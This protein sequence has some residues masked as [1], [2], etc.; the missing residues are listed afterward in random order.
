MGLKSLLQKGKNHIRKALVAGLASSALILSCG[1]DS[2]TSP[3]PPDPPSQNRAPVIN[4]APLTHIDEHSFYEY[5]VQA[6]DPD[7]DP[8]SYSLAESPSWL[9]VS[10]NSV[11]GNPPEVLRDSTIPV[12]VKVSDG[13]ASAEQSYNLN[14]QNLYNT[15][16]LS[17]EQISGLRVNDTSLSFFQPVNFA[18]NDLVSSGIS[19][20]TPSGLLREITSISSDRKTVR[21]TQATLEQVVRDASLSYSQELSPSTIQSFNAREGVSMSPAM[22]PSFNFNIGLT[23]V[24]LYD[25]DG[26]MNTTYDQIIA[27]GNL[28]FNTGF[29]FDLDLRGFKL[30]RLIFQNTTSDVA[31]ITIGSNLFGF[32]SLQEVKIAEYTFNPVIMGYLPAFVPLPVVAVPKLGVYVGLDPS[33]TN[34]LSIRVK[35][36]ASLTTRLRYDGGWVGTANFTNN[37]DFSIPTPTG[38]WDLTAYAGPRLN[39]LLY[40]IAGPSASVNTTLR[41]ASTS[42]DWKL[43]GGLEANLGVTMEVF[44]RGIAAHYETV[45]DY[46]KLLAE[47]GTVPVDSTFTDARDGQSYRL[48]KIGA[49]TW[50]AEN[51]NYNS[52]GSEY[53]QNDASYGNIYGRLYDW[54]FSKTAC[55]SNWHLPIEAEWDTLSIHLGYS[56]VSGGK[57]KAIGTIE[58]GTGRWHSPNTEAT[59]ESKFTAQPGGKKESGIYS[60]EG[61]SAY[62]WAADNTNAISKWLNYT[63]AGMNSFYSPYPTRYKFSIR[64]VRN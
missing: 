53:Y 54:N 17:S 56:E 24:I 18:V 27:N 9:S 50:M 42:G 49:Q 38:D 15:H 28:S 23:N 57:L 33:R 34:P 19:A 60:N 32:A 3:S 45:I 58:A 39:L 21:T 37:F 26:N 62:F 43:Y 1:R 35:Q 48:V 40:G 2:P 20:P 25:R 6:T 4:S 29:N 63:S 36:D 30:N 64:C 22:S 61:Y 10:N 55:P 46:E 31:D 12:K 11:Y 59:N 51:L 7:G 44:K 16:V 41:L 47:R 52:S 8:I 5:R 13:R 14:V